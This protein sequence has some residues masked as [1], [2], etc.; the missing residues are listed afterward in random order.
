MQRYN[1]V[2]G[3]AEVDRQTTDW[4]DGNAEEVARR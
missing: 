2:W 3:D 1:I 4:Y